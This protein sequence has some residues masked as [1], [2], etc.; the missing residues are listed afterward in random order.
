MKPCRPG[1]T[2]PR[3]AVDHWVV[4]DHDMR[5]TTAF[6]RILRLTGASVKTV[7]FTDQ[8]IVIG[9]RRRRRRLLCPCGT[10]TVRRYDSSRRRWRHLDFDACR[11]WLE[12]DIHRVNCRRCGRVRTEQVPWARPSPRHTTDFENVA[13]WLAQRVDKTGVSRLLRCSWEAVDAIVA[14]VVVDHLDGSRLNDLY[15]IGVDEISYKRGHKVLTIVADHDTGNVVWVGKDA[16]RP[17]SRSSS[18]PSDHSERRRFRRSAWTAAA[19]TC[20]SPRSRSRTPRSAWTRS[21][22]SSGQTRSSN[23]SI[24]PKHRRSPP[25]QACPTGANGDAP[26]TPCAP[27]ANASTTATARSSPCFADTATDSG[28]PGNSKSNCAISTAPPA[29]TTRGHTSN[30]GAPPRC[31]AAFPRSRTSYAASGSTS[32]RSSPQSNSAGRTPD[33]KAS[34]R[35]SGSSNDAGFGFRNLGALSAMIYLCLGGVAITLPT[36]T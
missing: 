5:V 4:V 10:P 18:P 14:R 15:R 22:S 25:D 26:A 12:A 34:T 11:V 33:S 8:G 19:S 28:A 24:A 21:T 32:T 16:P 31:A 27:A 7:T 35:R 1:V 30:G 17:R 23:R 13:A 2:P 3:P 9:L 20:P 36:E 6:N 29:L